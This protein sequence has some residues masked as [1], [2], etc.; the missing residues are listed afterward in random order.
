LINNYTVYDDKNTLLLKLVIFRLFNKNIRPL[1]NINIWYILYTMAS[2]F[3]C[4]KCNNQYSSMNSLSNHTRIYHPSEK[5]KKR[6]KNYDDDMYYCRYC[7]NKY[8]NRK[9]R[10]SHERRCIDETI[11]TENDKLKEEIIVIKQENTNLK[12]EV[13]HKTE[14]ITLHKKIGSANERTFKTFKSLNNELMKR[15][16]MNQTNNINITNNNNNSITNNIQQICNLG[17]EDVLSLLTLQEQLKI[18][19]SCYNSIEKLIEISYCGKYNQFKNVVITNLKSEHAYKYDTDKGYFITVNKSELLDDMFECRKL[20]IEEIYEELDNG[21]R[22]TPNQKRH[23]KQFL[24]EC[25]SEEEFKP[26]TNI[27]YPTF[28][29]YKK[30][31]INLLLYN[32]RD[33]ITKDIACLIKN[34][35]EEIERSEVPDILINETINIVLESVSSL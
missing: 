5:D 22:L 27:C 4:K 3:I 1:I 6:I 35:K 8:K 16:T 25:D 28:K 23:I 12:T 32:N 34:P 19:K 29:E 7:D 31:N 20:N 11:Y 30:S 15:S 24:D 33:H 2:V 21:N 17:E 9:T 14:V 13:K 18:V 10:W 26:D